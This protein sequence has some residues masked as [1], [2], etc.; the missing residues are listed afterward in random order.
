MRKLIAALAVM[1]I[2]FAGIATAQDRVDRHR[3]GVADHNT[4]GLGFHN[5]EAPVGFRWWLSGQKVGLDLGLGVT[6]DEVTVFGSNETLMGWTLDVGVPIVMRSWDRVHF[7]F[8][9]G[10]LYNSSEVA[11]DTNPGAGV[12]IEKENDTRFSL[13]AELE[14]EV[15]LANNFSVSAAQG[16]EFASFKPAV[17]PGAPDPDSN[18]SFRTIGGNFTSV[19]F[20]IYLFGPQ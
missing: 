15:F 7:M 12:T 6:S 11:F 17:P 3:D 10:L 2:G 20:H 4:I 16:I 9:P 1:M 13:R 19:G 14:A 8:R 18:T 5:T